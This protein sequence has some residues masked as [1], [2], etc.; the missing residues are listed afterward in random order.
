MSLNMVSEEELRAALRIHRVDPQTFEEGVRSRIMT[1]HG[2]ERTT[3]PWVGFSPFLRAAASFL[4][5]SVLGC[6]G[7]PVVAKIASNS[8]GAKLIGYLAFPAISLFVLL[9]ATLLSV[10]KIRAM[11]WENDNVP[12]EQ[13][14]QQ[15]AIRQWWREH[16]WGV[17]FVVAGSIGLAFSGASWL[18]FLFYIS[19]FG[20]LLYVLATLAKLG[21]GNRFVVGSSCLQGL[22]FLAQISAFPSIGDSDIHFL[23][24]SLVPV[25]FIGGAMLIVPILCFTLSRAEALKREYRGAFAVTAIGGFTA[26]ALFIVTILPLMAWMLAP[27]LWP[28]TPSSIKSHVE[29]FDRAPFSSAS[30]SRWEIPASWV[31]QSKLNPDFSKPRQLLDLEIAGEQNSFILGA[32]FRVGLISAEQTDQMKTYGAMRRSFVESSPNMLPQF[33]TSLELVDWVI[34]AAVLRDD[35]SPADRDILEQRLHATLQTLPDERF[36]TLVELLRATQLLNAIKRPVDPQMYRA[37]IHDL[38]REFHSLDSGGSALAGGFRRYRL[39]ATE[40]NKTPMQ[41]M[42]SSGMPGDLEATSHAIE[43]MTIYGIP[44][45]LDLNQIRSFLRPKASGDPERKWIAAVTLDW[46]EHLAN[47]QHPTWFEYLCYERTLLAAA[48]LASLCVFATISSP[49]P[50]RANTTSENPERSALA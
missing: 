28:A 41:T 3:T 35:L 39:A 46:L 16:K 22:M 31:V 47:I 19:S 14:A 23:D 36:V 45:E 34:R 26:S 10:L 15:E 42:L 21:I 1:T 4:P 33:I 50:K 12:S 9:G 6:R 24:Q 38:L 49:M 17:G 32:A 2:S 29:S 5:L 8:T 44:D 40:A 27:T 7:T 20:V 13:L 30:W 48:V 18:L 25:I 11:Q 37:K 43:L